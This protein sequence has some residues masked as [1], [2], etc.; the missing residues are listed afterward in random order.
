[1]ATVTREREA[2]IE[3][4][5]A[6]ANRYDM[7]ATERYEADADAFYR[8]TGYM[9]PGKDVPMAMG[10]QN[11]R[12]RRDAYDVWSAKRNQAQ[13]AAIL[14]AAA[15]LA[16]PP[17]EDDR[18][19]QFARDVL[20]LARRIVARPE[21]AAELAPHLMRLAERRGASAPGVLRDGE[22]TPEYI[23]GALSKAYPS[24][25]MIESGDVIEFAH[26]NDAPMLQR[27]TDTAAVEDWNGKLRDRVRQVYT[28]K[29]Q[30]PL[31]WRP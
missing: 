24:S 31:R 5:M 28:P 21:R 26:G 16:A 23:A 7:T 9:S 2:L 22:W 27:V 19:V 20:V 17:A 25:V 3:K 13:Q 30:A 14:E 8:E 15:A 6:L 18:E 12:E 4:L 10:G 29:S 11:E 1:M